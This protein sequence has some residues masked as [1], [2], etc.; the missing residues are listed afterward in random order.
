MLTCQGH[1]PT[2]ASLPEA[3]P[4]ETAGRPQ[5]ADKEEK[6]MGDLPR[7]P[8]L[9]PHPSV[10]LSQTGIVSST[11]HKFPSLSPPSHAALAGASYLT[12]GDSLVPPHWYLGREREYVGDTRDEFLLP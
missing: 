6:G 5:T 3:M 2:L 12:L 1:W 7:N 8:P 4:D 9:C 11:W 10:L